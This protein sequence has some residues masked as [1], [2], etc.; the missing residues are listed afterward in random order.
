[1]TTAQ[2]AEVPPSMPI[3]KAAKQSGTVL[4]ASGDVVTL[5]DKRVRLGERRH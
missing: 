2:T 1:M 4:E 5:D 3:V